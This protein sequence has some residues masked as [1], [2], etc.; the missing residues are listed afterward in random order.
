MEEE[1]GNLNNE[2][3]EQKEKQ[4]IT[5]ELFNVSIANSIIKKLEECLEQV[6]LLKCSVDENI[7]DSEELKLDKQLIEER[8]THQE[9]IRDIEKDLTVLEQYLIPLRQKCNFQ[10]KELMKK[11]KENEDKITCFSPLI[12]QTQ[13]QSKPLASTSMPLPQQ[14]VI[15]TFLQQF[16]HPQQQNQQLILQQ[17]IQHRQLNRTTP[18]TTNT[19][20]NILQQA[21]MKNCQHCQAFIHRNAPTCPNCKQKIVSKATKRKFEKR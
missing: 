19:S 6:D 18:I 21:K 14:I 13:Q 17:N 2:E 10:R 8:E 4:R 11:I 9:E 15:Q 16:L 7:E 3:N 20:Q 12:K 1:E 5:N